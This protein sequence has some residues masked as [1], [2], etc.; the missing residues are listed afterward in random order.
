[1]GDVVSIIG[2]KQSEFTDLPSDLETLAQRLRSGEEN[3]T[4]GLLIL[5]TTDKR[6]YH[7]ALGDPITK[8]EAHGLVSWT[9][10]QIK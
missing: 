9:A 10:T 2:K 7:I 4:R 6:I 8:L 5:E 1:M 3:A